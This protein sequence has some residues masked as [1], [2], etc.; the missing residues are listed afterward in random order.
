MEFQIT[1]AKARRELNRAG[2]ESDHSG[3]HMRDQELAVGDDL[4]TVAVIHGIVGDEK[5]F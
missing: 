3:E 4:Q 5:N 2:H 1:Q